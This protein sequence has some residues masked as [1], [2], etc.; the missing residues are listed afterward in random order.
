MWFLYQLQESYVVCDIATKAGYDLTES[1]TKR[2]AL[3]NYHKGI[4]FHG[5]TKI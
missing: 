4:N 2:T 1:E 3:Q 5:F